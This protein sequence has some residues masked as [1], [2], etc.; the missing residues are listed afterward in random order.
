MLTLLYHC[1]H[2]HPPAKGNP[3]PRVAN[4]PF[5]NCKCTTNKNCQVDNGIVAI[6]LT[7]QT[8]NKVNQDIVALR[9][10][11]VLA[12]SKEQTLSLVI[13]FTV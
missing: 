8:K 3:R 1:D 13:L 10:Q 12:E 5:Q 6:F 7:W 2:L 11:K 9:V 4:S